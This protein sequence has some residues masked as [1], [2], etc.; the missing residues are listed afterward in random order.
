VNIRP[1]RLSKILWANFV[2]G[3]FLY[4]GR[5]GQFNNTYANQIE[6]L[7]DEF[8][9]FANCLTGWSKLIKIISGAFPQFPR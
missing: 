8:G 3:K 1:A 5:G 6:H 9:K 7:H 2:R 4:T